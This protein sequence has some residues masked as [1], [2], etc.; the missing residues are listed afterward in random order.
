VSGPSNWRAAVVRDERVDALEV[1][2]VIPQE[3]LVP[4]RRPENAEMLD[5]SVDP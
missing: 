3:V 5:L 1:R 2:R 4:I